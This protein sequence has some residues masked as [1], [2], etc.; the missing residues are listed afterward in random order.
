M[1]HVWKSSFAY[2]GRLTRKYWDCQN[3]GNS[4]RMEKEPESTMV[5]M[6]RHSNG[7]TDTTNPVWLTCEE[8]Q[9]L[10]VHGS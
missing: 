1:P 10:K 4:V 6:K 8:F 7:L 2:D 5:L 3:C 9:A